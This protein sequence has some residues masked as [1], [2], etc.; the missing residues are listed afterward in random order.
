MLKMVILILM[1]LAILYCAVQQTGIE[2]IAKIDKCYHFIAFSQLMLALVFIGKFH[3]NHAAL[4]CCVFGIM[5]EIVQQFCTT[6]GW[7]LGDVI[8]NCLG[9]GSV[10]FY[11]YMYDF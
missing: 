6:R 3:P 11:L 7:E 8:A 10:W 4:L 5:I 2:S 9:F 1:L